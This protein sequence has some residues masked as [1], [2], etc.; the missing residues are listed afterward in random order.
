MIANLKNFGYMDMNAANKELKQNLR[1]VK[2]LAEEL[3]H[4]ME[5][6]PMRI[7]FEPG[8]SEKWEALRKELLEFR[9]LDVN[10]NMTQKTVLPDDVWIS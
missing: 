5:L 10:L 9:S 4:E 6:L 2:N 1:N 7:V 3:L 8:E